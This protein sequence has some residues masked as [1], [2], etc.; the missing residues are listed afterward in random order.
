M[1][2]KITYF[3]HG[4][5]ID[6]QNNISSGWSDTELSDLGKEQSIKLKEQIKGKIFDV[7]F[8]QI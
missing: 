7:V 4:T 5:T 8:A 6:N 1:A 2:V 3:V